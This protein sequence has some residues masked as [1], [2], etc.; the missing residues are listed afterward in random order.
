MYINLHHT[1]TYFSND[2]VKCLDQLPANH[3]QR[4]HSAALLVKFFREF[5]IS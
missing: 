1:L 2:R 3:Q 4:Q 5:T